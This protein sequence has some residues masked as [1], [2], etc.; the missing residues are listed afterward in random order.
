MGDW[1]GLPCSYPVQKEKNKR[2]TGHSNS[3]EALAQHA[4]RR[5]FGCSEAD[6]ALSEYWKHTPCL[7]R[8]VLVHFLT[9]GTA[10]SLVP[11]AHRRPCPKQQ[12]LGYQ[13]QVPEV[14]RLAH[15]LA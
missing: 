7:L 2:E 11:E 5:N 15:T 4:T 3:S 9:K 13:T 1:E 6:I 12:P 14:A 8:R 10:T